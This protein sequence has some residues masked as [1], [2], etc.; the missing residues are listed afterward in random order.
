MTQE[1]QEVKHLYE[2]SLYL[3]KNI[4]YFQN[5]DDFFVYHN[6]YGYI[7]K[8]S[9]DLVDFLEFFQEPHTAEEMEATYM[10]IFGEETLNEFLSI[11][12]TLAC[13]VPDENYEREKTLA[14]FPTVARWITVHQ[15]KDGNVTIFAYDIQAHNRV[16]VISLNNWQSALWKK[17]DGLKSVEEIVEDM[18]TVDGSPAQGLED[19]IMATLAQ[20][21]HCDIQALKLSAEPIRQSK[22]R[23]FGIPPY[24]ISTMPYEK[25]TA[26]VRTKADEK[27][28]IIEK[29]EE[30]L[31]VMPAGLH[32]ETI[33]DSILE[34]DRLANR[35]SSLLA[36]PHAILKN[37]SYGDVIFDLFEKYVQVSDETLEVLDIGGGLGETAATFA[38][39]FHKTWPETT[40]KYVIYAPNEAFANEQKQNC[41]GIDGIEIIVGEP[42]KLSATLGER[43]FDF[44]LCDEFLAELEAVSVRKVNL[45]EEEEE[46][47]E[48]EIKEGEELKP[49]S[50]VKP[51]TSEEKITFIGEGDA[52][53]QIFKY[54]LK[55][56]DAPEDF[57]LNNGS[58]RLINEIQKLCKF[59]TQ[60]LLVEF[61]EDVKYPVRT[62]EDGTAAF[63]QHFGIL[64]QA[65]EHLGYHTECGYWME[66][67]ELDRDVPMFATTRS[68]FKAM[69]CMFAKHGIALERRPYTEEEFK[70][71][72]KQ[73]GLNDD[74]VEVN[75]EN[76]EDR[77]SGLVPHSYRYLRL[78]KEIEI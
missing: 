24:L 26:M 65:A 67:I 16:A 12:R 56:N 73:A 44:I 69:R 59:T 39:R 53:Q 22:S 27:G 25:V 50:T 46:E 78:F 19:L 3:S 35:L 1:A 58:L 33:D 54:K 40:L 76:A 66:A 29:Y 52:I 70:A 11:F 6:L 15:P 2:G 37:R 18:R 7:L 62:F 55:L 64:R 43:K 38:K 31:R 47:E 10:E 4:D 5:G 9:E 75:F 21:T 48:E 17:L 60:V 45:A 77:I 34:H 63:S 61:G 57:Y 30:P 68:Q 51:S 8:M 14:M 41:N 23:R 71:L 72:L 20:W 28:N 13:L 74:V 32:Y 42:D 49:P 36:K